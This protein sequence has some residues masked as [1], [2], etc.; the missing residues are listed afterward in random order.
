L[1]NPPSHIVEDIQMLKDLSFAKL[2]SHTF[3]GLILVLGL[4]LIVDYFIPTSI[5]LIALE[6]FEN[7]TAFVGAFVLIGTIAGIVLDSIQHS[8]TICK[9]VS[10]IVDWRNPPVLDEEGKKTYPARESW[11]I[12]RQNIDSK[13]PEGFR[14][15]DLKIDGPKCFYAMP[16]LD[17]KIYRH[18]LDDYYHYSEFYMNLALA[19][20]FLAVGLLSFVGHRMIDIGDGMLFSLAVVSILIFVSIVSVGLIKLGDATEKEFWQ[21]YVELVT[22]T[23]AFKSQFKEPEKKEV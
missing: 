15:N 7:F 21:H 17:F 3:P 20:P 19:I 14:L 10:K 23:I 5:V 18:L 13:S 9:W 16:F 6:D 2:L 22:G 12:L 11:K 4:F 1:E 8:E